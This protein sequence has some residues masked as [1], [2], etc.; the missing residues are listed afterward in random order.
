ME[1]FLEEVKRLDLLKN[2]N[3][4]AQV[5]PCN[6]PEIREP[7]ELLTRQAGC[8]ASAMAEIKWERKK[9]SSRNC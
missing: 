8:L 7:L 9:N 1:L 5:N 2:Y 4:P 6:P 3:Q